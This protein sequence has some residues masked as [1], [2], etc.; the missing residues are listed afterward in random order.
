MLIGAIQK[1]TLIDYPGK[2]SALVFTQGCNFRC[3]YCH[4][5][6]LVEPSL[7]TPPVPEEEVL[8][9]LAKRRG[10]LDALVVTGGE[11]LLH[12][13]IKAFLRRVK[14]MGYLVKVD[15]NG[16]RPTVLEEILA[17]ALVDYIAMDIKAPLEKYPIVTA[18]PVDIEA[19]RASI[20]L[21]KQADVPY[22]FRTTL[23]RSL[24]VPEDILA[25]GHLI[26]GAAR[27]MLQPFV[28]SKHVEAGFIHAQTFSGEEIASVLTGLAPLVGECLVR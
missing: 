8:A 17:G 18:R 5:P 2:I 26:E 12:A 27:Y 13:D 9:F 14:A 21:I 7:F 25:I 6:E 28:A 10:L 20:G 23:A 11:P 19:I 24:L 4:N 15:T 22:E 16:S 3:P 1:T